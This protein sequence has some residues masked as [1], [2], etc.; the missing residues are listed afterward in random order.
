MRAIWMVFGV[1]A[2]VATTSLAHAQI[3]V[4]N[5]NLAQWRGDATAI[6]SVIEFLDQ[7]DHAGFAH[8]VSVFTVQEAN[9]ETYQSLLG[10]LGPEWSA[11][12]YTNTN[13][14]NYGGAQACFYHAATLTEDP[15]AHDDT[16][17]EAGRRADRWRFTVNGFDDPP[18]S[19]YV[20]S[21]HLKASNNSSAELDRETGA[22]RIVEN[23][24]ELPAGSRIIVTGDMNFYDNAELGYVVFLAGG[25]QD[26][27]GTGSWAG[28]SNTLKHT[29]SPRTIQAGGLASG[30]LDDRFD[31]QLGTESMYGTGGLTL[32]SG[33]YRSIGN[34]GNHYNIAIND[35]TNSFWPSDISGSNELAN[36]LHDASDHLP[37]AADYRMPAILDANFGGCEVGSVLVGY[38][39][40]CTLDLANTGSNAVPGGTADLNWSFDASGVLGGNAGSGSLAAGDAS[41]HELEVDTSAAGVFDDELSVTSTDDLTQHAPATLSVS[42]QVLR[43]ANPSFVSDADNNFY[44][45][46]LEIDPDSGDLPL[47]IQF[48]NYGWD[49]DQSR[50]DID[51]ISTPGAPVTFLGGMW[52]NVG[53]FPVSLPFTIDTN[54]LQP[55][56]IVRS[57][58]ILTSDEDLPGEGTESLHLTLNITV[59]EPVSS[60]D[61]DVTGDGVTDISDLLAMLDG[62]GGTDPLLDLNQDGVVDINDMLALLGDYG[63]V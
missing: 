34:D 48:W 3:R 33:T 16:Y 40:T 14:D 52:N 39:L 17:T 30:G 32:I 59:R 15:S 24:Q 11:A 19:F 62:Y 51:D 56:T 10:M 28:G 7:D 27:L 21:A 29:Q 4:V 49:S 60:C 55:G 37:L 53:P 22:I 38:P 13:E 47:G 26:P 41:Q 2:V 57:V 23:M 36:A 61:G 43:H 31:F 9:T 1:A 42:G 8:P 63:C 20:Y 46:F 58:T 50:M 25:L 5:W 54:G 18:V 6:A 12:T 45:Y 35:G 44:V